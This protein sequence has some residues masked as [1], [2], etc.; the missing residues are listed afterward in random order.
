MSGERL[1]AVLQTGE[2]FFAALSVESALLECFEV[3]LDRR[4]DP[5]LLRPDLRQLFCPLGRVAGCVFGGLGERVG[6]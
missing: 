2:A 1:E 4:S 6:D 3:A 5:G